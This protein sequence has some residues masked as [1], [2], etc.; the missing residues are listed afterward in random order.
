MHDAIQ[1]M[2]EWKMG[3]G[4]KF[5]QTLLTNWI[6]PESTSAMSDQKLNIVG[7]KGRIELDQ[8]K[9][10]IQIIVDGNTLEEPNPD[11]CQ[12]Y[13]IENGKT[14]WQG[15]GIES[16]ATFLEDVKQI[17]DGKQT[18]EDLENK[19]STFKEATISTAVIDAAG[20]SLTQ[21]GMWITIDHSYLK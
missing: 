1:C 18:P 2:V 5:T 4:T 12:S 20:K 7:T 14:H 8:K 15:Y 17:F 19:R 10:G 3:K 13:E 6:D 21:D 9:R 16:I 11:F